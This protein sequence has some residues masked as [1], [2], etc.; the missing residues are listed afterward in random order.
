MQAE[1]VDLT[2]SMGEFRGTFSRNMQ[3]L[4]LPGKATRPAHQWSSTVDQ[5]TLKRL[6]DQLRYRSDV[7]AETRGAALEKLQDI[8][9][10]LLGDLLALTPAEMTQFDLVIGAAELGGLPF[11]AAVGTDGEPL[12]VRTDPMVISPAGSVRTAFTKAHQPGPSCPG[13]STHGPTQ[14]KTSPTRITGARFDAPWS[15][16]PSH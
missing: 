3:Y 14:P 9:G 8:V 10:D 4:V 7:A 12:F 13:S 2:R 5:L 11:E 16:G 6:L 1:L 15:P